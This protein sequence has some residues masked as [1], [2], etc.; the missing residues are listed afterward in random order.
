MDYYKSIQKATM[1]LNKWLQD[2][3]RPSWPSFCR[4]MTMTY[5]FTRKRMEKLLRENWPNLDID[6]HDELVKVDA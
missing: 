3:N 5:G 2:A 1:D 4:N 6:K